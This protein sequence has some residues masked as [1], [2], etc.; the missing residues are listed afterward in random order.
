[1]CIISFLLFFPRVD[2]PTWCLIPCA[3]LNLV[4]TVFFVFAWRLLPAYGDRSADDILLSEKGFNYDDNSS[5]RDETSLS[6]NPPPIRTQLHVDNMVSDEESNAKKSD[7]LVNSNELSE[8]STAQSFGKQALNSGTSSTEPFT[9]AN[10]NLDS[11]ST[12]SDLKLPSVSNPYLDSTNSHTVDS[13]LTTN[14]SLIDGHIRSD[15]SNSSDSNFTSISQ[16]GVNP[17]YYAGA[18][19]KPNMQMM[20]SQNIP[21]P[22]QRPHPNGPP[23]QQHGYYQ[24]P[25]QPYNKGAYMQKPK[26]YMAM[27]GNRPPPGGGM[28]PPQ[29]PYGYYG[30]QPPRGQPQMNGYQNPAGYKNRQRPNL[31]SASQTRE[32]QYAMY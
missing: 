5:Y 29:N 17:R 7:V 28:L 30:G 2:W 4:A 25:N 21:P 22:Q 23:M 13:R 10:A 11:K 6:F 18:P 26:P 9:T 12:S 16:R 1:M 8:E 32:G 31:P 15:S 14:D 20:N 24:M 3:V 19:N 27:N